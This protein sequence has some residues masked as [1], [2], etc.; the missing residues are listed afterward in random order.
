MPTL[1]KIARQKAGVF[2]PR[3]PQRETIKQQAAMLAM[4]AIISHPTM[5]ATI[6]NACTATD[7]SVEEEIADMAVEFADALAQKLTSEK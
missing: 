3:N 6:E 2:S 1:A 7:Q 4:H 5:V